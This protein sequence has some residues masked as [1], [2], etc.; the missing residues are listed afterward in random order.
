MDNNEKKILL[1]EIKERKSLNREQKFFMFKMFFETYLHSLFLYGRNDEITV[2]T[3]SIW[4]KYNMIE[5]EEKSIYNYLLNNSNKINLDAALD[6][7]DTLDEV[8]DETIYYYTDAFDDILDSCELKAKWRAQHRKKKFNTLVETDEYRITAFGLTLD[9]DSVK[10]YLN[11]PEEFWNY[12]FKKTAFIDNNNMFHDYSV[13]MRFDNE[14]KLIDMRVYVPRV[15]SLKTALIN[16]H[17]FKHAYDLFLKLGQ[18]ITNEEEYEIV[19]HNKEEE[20]IKTYVRN[21][22]VF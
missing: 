18:P 2:E 10:E 9:F 6:L 4:N 8:N 3:K 13:L 1:A 5:K 19:A 15:N 11:Y 16:I 17:E 20:F 12:I 22:I 7:I 21:K 14:E